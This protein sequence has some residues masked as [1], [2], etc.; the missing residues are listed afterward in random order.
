VFKNQYSDPYG[1]EEKRV[2]NSL[3]QLAKI[4]K[5]G[6]K[7]SGLEDDFDWKYLIFLIYVDVPAYQRQ[8]MP[9]G[10]LSLRCLREQLW[11][12]TTPHVR[13]GN[14]KTRNPISVLR[15]PTKEV[16]NNV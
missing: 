15:T 3:V 7:Y 6:S 8:S 2:T 9:D 5:D 14:Q 4:Y 16:S 12:S 11:H 13:G 1:D 10:S